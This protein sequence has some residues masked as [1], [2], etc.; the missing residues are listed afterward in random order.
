MLKFLVTSSLIESAFAEPCKLKNE[1]GRISGTQSQN[2]GDCCNFNLDCVTG[3]CA[4]GTCVVTIRECDKDQSN[5]ELDDLK[6]P[7]IDS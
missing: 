4:G 1:P 3:C 7:N 2:L 5:A 6:R